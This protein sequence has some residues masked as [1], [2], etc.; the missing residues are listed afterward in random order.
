MVGGFI[1]YERVVKGTSFPIRKDP[2]THAECSLT[3]WYPDEAGG[4]PAAAEFS[5]KYEDPEEGY[6]AKMS[7]RA[8][9][10]FMAIQSLLG[11]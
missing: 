11:A 9:D 10:A 3:I 6:T 7:K 4:K 2:E 1:A 5:F 8:Y